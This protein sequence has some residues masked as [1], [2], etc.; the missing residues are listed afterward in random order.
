MTYDQIFNPFFWVVGN[1][2][3]ILMSAE[4]AFYCI[5]YCFW[6]RWWERPGGRLIMAFTSSLLGVVF[7]V[8]VGLVSNPLGS[9][10]YP[11]DGLV[12]RPLARTLIYGMVAF[13]I[14]RLDITLIARYRRGA[15]LEFAVEP[16][17]GAVPSSPV[18]ENTT[19]RKPLRRR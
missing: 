13:T 15:A 17:P 9:F 11:I 10:T 19:P 6:F 16:R 12:W 8:L 18:E 7:L 2:F 4:L 5:F 3:L 1:L 14:L